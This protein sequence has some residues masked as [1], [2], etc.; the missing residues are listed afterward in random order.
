VKKDSISEW[1]QND[2]EA[3]RKA[4]EALR[5]PAAQPA[6]AKK[7]APPEPAPDASDPTEPPPPTVGSFEDDADPAAGAQADLPV[8]PPAP[9]V[10]MA[11]GPEVAAVVKA[12]RSW[13]A[14]LGYKSPPTQDTIVLAYFKEWNIDDLK[15]VPADVIAKIKK[16]SDTESVFKAVARATVDPR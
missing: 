3:G 1:D 16:A 5:K 9:A 8:T 12:M 13:C 4:L 11:T 10:K 14:D 7:A 15:K 6:A 2:V